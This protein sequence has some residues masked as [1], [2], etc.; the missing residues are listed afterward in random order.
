LRSRSD[1]RRQLDDQ[2]ARKVGVECRD[3]AIASGV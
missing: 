3:G 2:D 1:A